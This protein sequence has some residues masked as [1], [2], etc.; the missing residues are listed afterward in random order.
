MNTAKGQ[1]GG[2]AARLA[3]GPAPALLADV[4]TITT[5]VDGSTARAKTGAMNSVCAKGVATRNGLSAKFVYA[6]VY[7]GTLSAPGSGAPPEVPDL[8]PPAGTP[9]VAPDAMGR[10]Q[11]PAVPN[12]QCAAAAPFPANTLCIWVVFNGDAA[13]HPA[14]SHFGGQRS[15]VTDCEVVAAANGAAAQ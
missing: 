3:S 12:A 8:M 2:G 15:N 11:H 10:W 7:A 9:R 13:F 1:A 4:I 14:V 6:R 5:P